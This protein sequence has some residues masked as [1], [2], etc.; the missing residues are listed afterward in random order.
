M[1]V[2]TFETFGREVA[3]V[4]YDGTLESVGAI[5]KFSGG[6]L[7][8]R[9]GSEP[10]F[11]SPFG[12]VK[13]EKTDWIIEDVPGVFT[14]IKDEHRKH[15]YVP[16]APTREAVSDYFDNEIGKAFAD[17]EGGLAV[18]SDVL[19]FESIDEP[20]KARVLQFDEDMNQ[21]RNESVFLIR[22]D[23]PHSKLINS[24]MML[25][26]ISEIKAYNS[27][28][29]GI[30]ADGQPYEVA[31]TALKAGYRVTR[32]GWNGK[33][34]WLCMGEGQQCH[35]EQFWNK[36]TRQFAFDIGGYADV[37]PYIVMKTADD[38]ILMGWL[39]SQSDQFATDWIILEN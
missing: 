7:H 36:H 32:E 2:I 28:L 37:L 16:P 33:G 20:Q 31:L 27:T 6:K 3:A 38:K 1:T 13:L 5:S 14:P 12:L 34:M 23:H 39:A 9:F 19:L 8:L 21:T 17:D 24:I 26:G 15:F 29:P 30:L 25:T 22:E 4:Q 35:A 11:M 10:V 18:A